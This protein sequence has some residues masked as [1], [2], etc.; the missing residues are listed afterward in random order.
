MAKKRADAAFEKETSVKKTDEIGKEMKKEEKKGGV[1]DVHASTEAADIV[2]YDQDGARLRFDSEDFK[3]LPD[4]VLSQLH[5][6][7]T[8]DYFLAHASWKQGKKAAGRP[9]DAPRLE[10]LDPLA[11]RASDK[12]NVKFT[13]KRYEERWHTFWASAEDVEEHKDIGYRLVEKDEPVRVRCGSNASGYIAL[14]GQGGKDELV[15]MKVEKSKYDQHLEAVA[16]KSQ[17]RMKDSPRA[18]LESN[19]DR[20]SGGRVKSV[21][22]EEEVVKA[23]TEVTADGTIRMTEG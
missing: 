11:R 4:S 3:E 12:V 20:A 18:D 17:D 1:F 22:V 6:E 19:L 10:I 7:N 5:Y 15:L 23:T 2:K 8:R 16:K 21:R 14:K 9:K 13:D